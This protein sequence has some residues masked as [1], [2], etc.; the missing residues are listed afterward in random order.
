MWLTI[1]SSFIGLIVGLTII[2]EKYIKPHTLK[3]KLKNLYKMIEEWF[4][5]IDCNLENGLNLSKLNN[6]ESKF[7]NYVQE[8]LKH[9][10]LKPNIRMVRKWN[11]KMGIKDS[12]LDSVSLFERFSRLPA[13][14]LYLDIY[15]Y[16]IIGNFLSFY[17]VYQEKSGLTNYAEVE[18]RIKFLK[19]YVE[20]I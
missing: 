7:T 18:M 17:K 11:K 12:L 5:E 4:D 2:Y 6:M 10:E 15:V 3:A 16:Q 14:G 9:Y 1:V 8:H 20:S 19:F 13:Q